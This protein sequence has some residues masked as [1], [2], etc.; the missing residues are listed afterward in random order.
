MV[1]LK[2]R[3]NIVNSDTDH[4]LSTIFFLISLYLNIPKGRYSGSTTKIFDFSILFV[5][6]THKIKC[7]FTV[8]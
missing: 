6:D 2:Y 7:Y 4:L 5:K 8:S 1:D 3:L